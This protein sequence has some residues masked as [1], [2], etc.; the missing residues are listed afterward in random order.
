MKFYR[1]NMSKSWTFI[2]NI[3][4]IVGL[5]LSSAWSP[6]AVCRCEKLYMGIWVFNYFCIISA[7]V[8]DFGKNLRLTN[9]AFPKHTCRNEHLLRISAVRDVARLYLSASFLGC[10][11]VWLSESSEAINELQETGGHYVTDEDPGSKMED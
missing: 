9:L 6:A 4:R 7:V 11:R 8:A 2:N 1:A 5:A 3:L 10:P